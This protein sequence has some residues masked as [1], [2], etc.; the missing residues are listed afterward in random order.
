MAGGTDR[1]ATQQVA[2]SPRR[3]RGRIR[4]ILVVM[5]LLVVLVVVG[6]RQ[7]DAW[8]GAPVAV[9]DCAIH[10]VQDPG[11]DL[12]LRPTL[13]TPTYP[14]RDFAAWRHGQRRVLPEPNPGLRRRPAP[15]G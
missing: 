15:I 7:V 2:G 14:A 13:V 4:L 8:S 1:P 5:L 3:L 6:G 10:A 12:P 11:A 9:K